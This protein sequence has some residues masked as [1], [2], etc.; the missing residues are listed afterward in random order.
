[1]SAIP[2]A[3]T[4]NPYTNFLNV[5]TQIANKMEFKQ[6]KNKKIKKW[7]RHWATSRKVVGS[8]PTTFLLVVGSRPNEVNFFQFT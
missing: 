1:M 6:K 5:Y 3:I 7:L 4:P 2:Q 8:R